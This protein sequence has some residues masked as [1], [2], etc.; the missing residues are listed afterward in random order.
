MLHVFLSIFLGILSGVITGLIPGIHINLVSV[1]V[2][3]LYQKF[4]NFVGV[5][6]I[7]IFIFSMSI[8][9]TFVDCIPSIYLGAPDASQAL[10]ALPGHKMLLQGKGRVAIFLTV[11][12]SYFTLLFSFFLF[13]LF[14]WLMKLINPFLGRNTGYI[15]IIIVIYLFII[16][17]KI[18]KIL[19]SIFI[20]FFSG[21]FGLIVL[22]TES[23]NQPLFH[24]LSGLFGISLLLLSLADNNSIPLQNKKVIFYPTH[25]I[26][27]P[28]LGASIA[29]FFSAFLPG[30]GSSQAAIISSQFLR[31]LG[32]KGFMI[33]V[34]GLNTASMLVSLCTFFILSKARNGSIVVI[35]D[36]IEQLDFEIL[37]LLLL[38]GLVVGGFA[39]FIT[40]RLSNIFSKWIQKVNYNLLVSSI[41]LFIIVLS[42]IFDGLHGFLILICATS[43]GILATKLEVGKNNLLGCLLLSV[44]LFFVL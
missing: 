21:V 27:L 33:L 38:T 36:F 17:K 14:A 12:G 1:V 41:I 29:G 2:L 13:W 26:K 42:I 44:I 6:E 39:V 28:V 30:F 24:M 4:S 22:N 25:K 7:C 3:S 31:N 18:N 23:L 16:Q 11:I 40:L 34:G 20:F 9:H 15:L 8:T 35:K 43:L 10:L 5:L 19:K 37:I 32:D